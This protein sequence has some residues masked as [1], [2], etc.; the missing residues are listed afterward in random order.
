MNQT[1]V[2]QAE[3]TFSSH[4]EHRLRERG[5]AV[6]EVAELLAV[7]HI[8]YEGD[9]RH[10]LGRVVHAFDDIRIVTGVVLPDQPID[11][12]TVMW[13]HSNASAA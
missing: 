7:P 3:L 6:H 2:V 5:F 11:V 4:A 13:R 9:P 1:S 12:I 8:Q 10:G